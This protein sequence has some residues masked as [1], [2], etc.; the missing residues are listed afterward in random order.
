MAVIIGDIYRSIET[1]SRGAK[2]YRW[3][4]RQVGKIMS[5]RGNPSAFPERV[6]QRHSALLDAGWKNRRNGY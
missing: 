3:L 1:D 2:P 5:N 6:W 4:V